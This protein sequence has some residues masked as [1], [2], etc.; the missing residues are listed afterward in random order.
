[1]NHDPVTQLCEAHSVAINVGEQ[2]RALNLD[3][4]MMAHG[5]MCEAMRI[6]LGV[7][8]NRADQMARGF[9][10]IALA[11]QAEQVE[12]GK[13]EVIDRIIGGAMKTE[14]KFAH[15]LLTSFDANKRLLQGGTVIP[16]L[17]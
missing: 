13:A 9:V 7:D 1:M 6:M 16:Q 2:I 5:L 11:D 17:P 12:K 15:A 4:T 10:T 3:S 8:M 14:P